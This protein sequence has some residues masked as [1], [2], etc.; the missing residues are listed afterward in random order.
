VRE[1]GIVALT[2]SS[3]VPYPG[4]VTLQLTGELDLAGAAPLQDAV[5]GAVASAE[6]AAVL[7]DLDGVT[8]LDSTGIGSL[9][10]GWRTATDRGKGYRIDNARGMVREVL[11]ITGVLATLSGEAPAD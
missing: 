11:S 6:V 1:G 2:I 4:L 5:T 10:A 9:V 3:H 8:F 7:V